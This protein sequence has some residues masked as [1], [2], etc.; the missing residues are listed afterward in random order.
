MNA[1]IM[2]SFGKY[3]SAHLSG[4]KCPCCAKPGRAE[5][6][7]NFRAQAEVLHE[8]KY[9]YNDVAYINGHTKVPIVCSVHGEFWQKPSMHLVGQGCPE[10]AKNALPGFY[11]AG[12]FRRHPELKNK[13]GLFYCIRFSCATD[14]FYKVGIAQSSK[15]VK[16][17]LGE[18]AYQAQTVAMMPLPLFQA[19]QKEQAFLQYVRN[20]G[21]QFVPPTPLL[22]GGNTECFAIKTK[23]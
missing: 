17:F 2:E 7:A 9:G 15:R 12:T 21:L 22:N 13:L 3:Q 14:V 10:C 18:P 5:R 19:W 4:C 16:K 1:P 8:H 6:A 20:N 23:I 11:R